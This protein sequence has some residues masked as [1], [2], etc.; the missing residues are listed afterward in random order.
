MTTRPVVAATDGSEESLRAVQWA[1]LEARRHGAPLRIVSVPAMPPRMR[2]RDESPLT[3]ASTLRTLSLQA[4]GTAANRADELAPGLIIGTELLPVG[5]PALAV[6]DCGSGA[7]MLVVGSRG[8]GGVAAAVLGSV[9]RY[10]AVH[11]SCPVVVAREET[12]AV[13][14]QVVVGIRGGSDGN[15]ALAFAFDE[16]S[17]RKVT[18]MVVHST[19]EED[20]AAVTGILS[21]WREK[22]PEVPVRPQV[23]RGHAAQALAA[24]SARADLV[25][26]GRHRTARGSGAIGGIQHAVLDHA[27]GPVAIVPSGG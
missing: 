15:Q 27:H 14:G 16:A 4:L 2:A 7:L 20:P 21:G 22:Y 13:H 3:V 9:S 10:V 1:A 5:P 18:L 19:T 24:Y 6:T 17:R 26:I 23:T 8:A 11:A 25:V 12:D